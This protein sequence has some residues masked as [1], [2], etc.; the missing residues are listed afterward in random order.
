MISKKFN[1]ICSISF[2][3]LIIGCINIGWFSKFITGNPIIYNLCA[4]AILNQGPFIFYK[5]ISAPFFCNFHTTLEVHLLGLIFSIFGASVSSSKF[6]NFLLFFIFLFFYIKN[7]KNNRNLKLNIFILLCWLSIPIVQSAFHVTD[8]DSNI[9]IFIIPIIFILLNKHKYQIIDFIWLCFLL[10]IL[11]WTKEVTGLIVSLSLVLSAF[12][13]SKKI[14]LKILLTVS[15]SWLFFLVTYLYYSEYF[16]IPGGLI[17]EIFLRL[18]QTSSDQDFTKLF[19]SIKGLLV[20][21]GIIP[22]FFFMYHYVMISIK[23]F[24][25]KSYLNYGEIFVLTVSFIALLMVIISGSFYPR[26]LLPFILPILM[27]IF[28]KY[29]YYSEDNFLKFNKV[30]FFILIPTF[31]FLIFVSKDLSITT[32]GFLNE[33]HKIPL[34]LL[35]LMFPF[36]ALIC[37][38]FIN[39]KSLWSFQTIIIFFVIPNIIS[40]FFISTSGSQIGSQI[41]GLKGFEDS[42]HFVRNKIDDNSILIT[43]HIDV[44]FYFKNNIYHIVHPALDIP[45]HDMKSVEPIFLNKSDPYFFDLHESIQS[46]FNGGV[47]NKI[48]VIQRKFPSTPFNPV[49][50]EFFNKYG[51][52]LCATNFDDYLVYHECSL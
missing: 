48:F 42:I 23:F 20:W 52:V 26:Y 45:T 7:A 15:F 50:I 4:D 13:Y 36:L 22:L 10:F 43:D 44:G 9:S 28:Y 40:A 30:F 17:L 1:N 51:S 37:F 2:L 12:L 46:E 21:V 18:T 49:K 47:I 6:F 41:H 27:L 11:I 31:F 33:I 19:G 25:I 35:I 14:I 16:N 5:G 24:K 39:K 38:V 32:S 34:M 8:P 29:N 3:L